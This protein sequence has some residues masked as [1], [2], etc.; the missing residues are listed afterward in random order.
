MGTEVDTIREGWV[1]VSKYQ[2]FNVTEGDVG[3][4]HAKSHGGSLLA[5]MRAGLQQKFEKGWN[6]ANIKRF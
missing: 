4:V 2:I 1:F 6:R 5:I 3:I